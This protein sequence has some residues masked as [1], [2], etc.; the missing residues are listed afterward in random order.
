MSKELQRVFRV[1]VLDTSA[2]TDTRLRSILGAGDIDETIRMLANIIAKARITHFIEVYIPPSAYEEARRFLLAN[3][4][5]IRS[6]EQ[7]ATWLTVK[8]P[9]RHELSL[10]ASVLR[11]LVDE[12]RQRIMRGLRVAEEHVRRAFESGSRIGDVMDTITH[13]QKLGA[14]IR[15]LRERY[16]ESTRH[17]VVDSVEDIDVI[18][19]A[20][21]LKA[22]LVT[23]DDGVRRLAEAL[24]II[25]I[26]PVKFINILL[27]L[28]KFS[29]SRERVER[30]KTMEVSINERE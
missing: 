11:D 7:L 2:L 27:G 20:Y 24:G 26:D 4:V 10:P 12:Y 8:P 3:G 22:I 28:L 9:S 5:T 15:G 14:L 23:N 29:S 19:L 21:E 6:F 17:G 16:R 1:Y 30:S 13:N 25:V 18:L